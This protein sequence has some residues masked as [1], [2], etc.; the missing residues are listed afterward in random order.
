MGI[1]PRRFAD[2]CQ[3]IVAW[4]CA[5]AKIESESSGSVEVTL[6]PEEFW[7][8]LWNGLRDWYD[9]GEKGRA[10]RLQIR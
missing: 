1:A 2:M 9:F 4:A 7:L 5:I 3:T 8:H 6:A 10:R